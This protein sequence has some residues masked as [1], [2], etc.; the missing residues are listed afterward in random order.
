MT[1]RTFLVS[2]QVSAAEQNPPFPVIAG[3]NVDV[4][5]DFLQIQTQSQLRSAFEAII[6]KLA[7]EG[8]P[9]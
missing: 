5:I 9:P 8:F 1:Q 2:G 4:A 3:T 6:Q 7:K